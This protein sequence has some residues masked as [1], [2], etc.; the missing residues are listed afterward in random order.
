MP[1]K[2]EKRHD[3]N[4]EALQLLIRQLK[5]GGQ[6]LIAVNRK[7]KASE[8]ALKESERKLRGILDHTFQFIGLMTLDGILIDANRTALNF[9]GL[10]EA[11]VL[12]KPFWE[13]G[14]WTHSPELQEKLRAAIKEAAE[15]TL[16]RFEA[17]HRAK[18][19]SLHDIDFSLSP[20]KNE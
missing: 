13:T 6:Q 19:G 5:A 14:W 2:K 15:G 10:E 17:T 11:M 12:N 3:N 18:D 8:E 7:L 1:K 4:K 20:I 9:V 16:V